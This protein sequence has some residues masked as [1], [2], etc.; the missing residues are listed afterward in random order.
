MSIYKRCSEHH[1]S[2]TLHAVSSQAGEPYLQQVL[3]IGDRRRVHAV[4]LKQ[5][6]RQ[7]ACDCMPW[8]LALIAWYE[9]PNIEMCRFQDFQMGVASNF[10]HLLRKGAHLALQ[11]MR[12]ARKRSCQSLRC[13][14]AYLLHV[15]NVLKQ[16]RRVCLHGLRKS[17]WF[18]RGGT[19]KRAKHWP[20]AK[21]W[22]N[23]VWLWSHHLAWPGRSREKPP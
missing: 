2:Q 5:Q 17:S 6:Y 15:L 3:P 4:N 11:N 1:N 8:A 23:T 22:Q 19:I 14:M 13:A 16:V 7:W 21:H 12:L 20:E 18:V 9:P 10:G